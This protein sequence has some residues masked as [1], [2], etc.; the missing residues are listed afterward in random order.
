MS[1]EAAT[2][3][4]RAF[5]NELEGIARSLDEMSRDLA[6]QNPSDTEFMSRDAGSWMAKVIKSRVEV[7]THTMTLMITPMPTVPQSGPRG[8]A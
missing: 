7:L 6:V 5:V 3:L 8:E 1:Q 2:R 4:I